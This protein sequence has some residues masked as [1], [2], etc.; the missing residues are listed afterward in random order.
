MTT[1]TWAHETPK[2]SNHPTFPTSLQGPHLDSRS[3]CRERCWKPPPQLLEQV[4]LGTVGF[5]TKIFRGCHMLVLFSHKRRDPKIVMLSHTQ[6]LINFRMTN[7]RALTKP[8]KK[9][10][11]KEHVRPGNVWLLEMSCGS[12]LKIYRIFSLLK[13]YRSTVN[14]W[15]ALGSSC[16]K[17]KP[18]CWWFRN[19]ANHLGCIKPCK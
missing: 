12:L 8:P 10:E 17:V 9:Y 15:W 14:R 18:F 1:F 13:R 6:L 11:L 16:E 4:D 7:Y 19:P 5:W 3:V 2:E